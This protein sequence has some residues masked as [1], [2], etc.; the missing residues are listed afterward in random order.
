MPDLRWQAEA[1]GLGKLDLGV[2][3]LTPVHEAGMVVVPGLGRLG[4]QADQS[5]C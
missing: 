1:V 2:H 5:L 4:H 3:K